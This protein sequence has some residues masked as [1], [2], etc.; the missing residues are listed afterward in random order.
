MNIRWSFLW[1][2]RYRSGYDRKNRAISLRNVLISVIGLTSKE[3]RRGLHIGY[4]LRM[5]T[6]VRPA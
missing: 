6:A 1:H 2:S 4:W 3:Q 5:R